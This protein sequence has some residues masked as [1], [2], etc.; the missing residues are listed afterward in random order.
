MPKRKLLSES[1]EG[2]RCDRHDENDAGIASIAHV[3]DPEMAILGG[4]L[5]HDNELLFTYLDRDLKRML[6]AATER[7]MQVRPSSFGY[8]GG[9]LGAA[10]VALEDFGSHVAK[11]T[12]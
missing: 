7:R 10:A 1:E 9:V 2:N 11:V 5:A 4:G 3:L 12:G 6:F 8:Y